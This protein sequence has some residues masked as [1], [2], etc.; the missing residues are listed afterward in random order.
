M[1]G[2]QVLALEPFGA[3]TGEGGE[4]QDPPSVRS[5]SS[6]VHAL[7]A[8]GLPSISINAVSISSIHS[9]ASTRRRTASFGRVVEEAAAIT[10]LPLHAASQRDNAKVAELA[11]KP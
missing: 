6:S 2:W 1:A 5:F 9:T 8:F 7:S 11:D 3:A 10:R 4:V